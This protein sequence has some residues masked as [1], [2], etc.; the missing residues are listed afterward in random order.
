[1][2]VPEANGYDISNLVRSTNSLSRYALGNVRVGTSNSGENLDVTVGPACNMTALDA[3]VHRSKLRKRT[4][5]LIEPCKK[6]YQQTLILLLFIGRLTIHVDCGHSVTN[7][8]Q[9][10]C[11]DR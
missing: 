8:F 1:M 10:E 7:R 5:P 4:H 3:A 6:Q 2:V 11:L 9:V